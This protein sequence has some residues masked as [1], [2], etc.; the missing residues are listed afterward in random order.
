MIRK[1]KLPPE[2]FRHKLVFLP[3][4]TSHPHASSPPLPSVHCSA[5]P[6]AEFNNTVPEDT[7]KGS[8][9]HRNATYR[10]SNGVTT[11]LHCLEDGTW[12]DDLTPC[13]APFS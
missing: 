2:F 10:C 12:S 3:P 6:E 8:E 5:P 7:G 9:P 4:L 13:A 11:V 1:I